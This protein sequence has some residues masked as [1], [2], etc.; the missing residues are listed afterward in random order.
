MGQ[1]PGAGDL[2]GAPGLVGKCQAGS[3]GGLDGSQPLLTNTRTGNLSGVEATAWGLGHAAGQTAWPGAR[4]EK[5]V[6]PANGALT[7]ASHDAGSQ[8]P[9][10]GQHPSWLL[11]QPWGPVTWYTEALTEEAQ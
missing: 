5:T 6:G 9:P 1:W 4:R 7:P 11:G 3:G 10:R 8:H 2:E